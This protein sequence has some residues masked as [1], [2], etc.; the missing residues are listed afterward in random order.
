MPNGRCYYHGGK[1]LSG[2]A[3]GFF[4]HGRF[5]KVLPKNF[6]ER[7]RKG[8]QDPALHSLQSELIAL[9]SFIFGEMQALKDM[10]VGWRNQTRSEAARLLRE[11]DWLSQALDRE[12]T[13]FKQ[14]LADFNFDTQ[15]LVEKLGKDDDEGLEIAA[16]DRIVELFDQRRKL[17]ESERKRLTELE[18][19]VTVEEMMVVANALLQAVKNNVPDRKQIDNVQREF[20]AI[21]G[22]DKLIQQDR[23]RKSLPPV[24]DVSNE[25]NSTGE[26]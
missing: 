21:L 8:W 17:V 1:S 16:R 9:D 11:R 10:P 23:E 20:A 3:N 6:A 2:V 24:I 22:F 7:Y 18:Q 4:K 25:N 12:S 26:S 15:K 13:A 14:R 5:S 19:K